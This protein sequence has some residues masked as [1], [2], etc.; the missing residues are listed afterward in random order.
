M[1]IYQGNN[2]YIGG[3]VYARRSLSSDK[4]SG[5]YVL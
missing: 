2:V 5:G 3:G 4:S 1:A